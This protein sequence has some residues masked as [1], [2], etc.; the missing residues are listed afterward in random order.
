MGFL[1]DLCND[2]EGFGP[3]NDDSTD[4]TLCA[5]SCLI[6]LPTCI[7]ILLWCIGSLL[8]L[9][10]RIQSIPQNELNKR[11]TLIASVSTQIES[12]VN[13]NNICT[14]EMTIGFA[15]TLCLS[16]GII[17]AITVA[18]RDNKTQNWKI[19]TLVSQ[20][21]AWVCWFFFCFSAADAWY[22]VRCQRRLGLIL[23]GSFME[24][25]PH[26]STASNRHVLCLCTSCHRRRAL[27]LP[28]D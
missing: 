23:L 7:V 25:S 21:L 27:V 1:H 24:V 8:Q 11:Q 10:K 17:S 2:N 20:F 6:T 28:S 26:V 5:Q 15:I 13:P 18:G 9:W 3:I 22:C 19:I 16:Y 4:L 14:F 12:S